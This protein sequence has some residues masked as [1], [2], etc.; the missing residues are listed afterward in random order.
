MTFDANIINYSPLPFYKSADEQNAKR[1]WIYD[2]YPLYA[3]NKSL[4]PFQIVREHKAAEISV[5]GVVYSPAYINIDGNI[6]MAQDGD[7]QVSE[8]LPEQFPDKKL[9]IR[10]VHS[11]FSIGAYAIVFLNEDYERINNA[12]VNAVNNIWNLDEERIDATLTI[13]DNCAHIYV[14]TTENALVV[15]RLDFARVEIFALDGQ[16]AG[17]FDLTIDYGTTYDVLMNVASNL[18]LAVGRYY[19]TVVDGY[20]EQWISDI[21]TVVDDDVLENGNYVKL[22][23][24]DQQDLVTDSGIISY[25][26]DYKNVI[27]LAT[28]LAKPEYV[29]EEDGENRDGYFFQEKQISKKR[30][31]FGFYAPEYLLDVLRLVRLADYA[32]VS[33]KGRE[34]QCSEILLTPTWESEGDVALVEGEFDTNTVVKAVGRILS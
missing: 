32:K 29:Y 20:G 31:K 15:S 8:F 26:N 19:L 22:E 18:D 1:W 28:D 2:I 24:Y 11:A 27:Y 3:S 12:G 17:N 6:E 7:N 33:Y 14:D 10:G 34:Y 4:I 30:Y 23:W 13:P 5:E 16:S 9:V 25:A 21:L